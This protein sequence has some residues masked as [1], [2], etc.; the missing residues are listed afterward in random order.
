MQSDKIMFEIYRE[1]GYNRRFRVLYFTELNDH[2]REKE[3]NRAMAG[4]HYYDGFIRTLK[5]D[6]AK[7]AIAEIVTRLNHGEEVPLSEV[8]QK[9]EPYLSP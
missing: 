2:N 9:L 3:I 8:H 1:A 6:E 5:K 4:E 7:S